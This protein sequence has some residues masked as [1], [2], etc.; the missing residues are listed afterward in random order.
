MRTPK[1]IVY[2]IR[3]LLRWSAA[4]PN[5]RLAAV[6]AGLILAPQI[7]MQGAILLWESFPMPEDLSVAAVTRIQVA[8]S[9]WLLILGMG[10]GFVAFPIGCILILFAGARA[11]RDRR[12]L[13]DSSFPEMPPGNPPDM[14]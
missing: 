3:D 11:W 9:W 12:R 4:Y 13:V 1:G 10:G 7:L 14:L 5:G 8:Q 2:R 6:G